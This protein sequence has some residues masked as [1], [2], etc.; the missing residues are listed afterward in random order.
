MKDHLLPSD[1]APLAST[2][3]QQRKSRLASRWLLI[4]VIGRSAPTMTI[5]A[6]EFEA[7]IAKH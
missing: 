1:R 2:M 4:V 6:D 3:G 7:D 5:G